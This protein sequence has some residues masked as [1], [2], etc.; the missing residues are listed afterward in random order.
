MSIS[1]VMV[2]DIQAR[3]YSIGFV[4]VPHQTSPFAGVLLEHDVYFTVLS[5]LKTKTDIGIMGMV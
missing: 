5:G 1:I 2:H 3:I 4:I